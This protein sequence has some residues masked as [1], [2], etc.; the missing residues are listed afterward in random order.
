MKWVKVQLLIQNGSYIYEPNVLDGIELTSE[1]KGTP[2]KLTFKCFYDKKADFQEGNPVSFKVNNKKVFFGYIFTKKRDKDKIISVTCYDQLRYFK[3]KDTYCYEGLTAAQVLQMI[4]NDFGLKTGSIEDTGYVI[5]SRIEN[6]KTLFDVCQNALDLTLTNTNKLY[7]MYDDFARITLKSI[8]SMKIPLLIDEETGQSF[9]YS[10]SI[11]DQTYNKIKLTFDNKSTG[12]RD[13]YI[14]QDSGNINNWGILQFYDT[15]QEG[16]NGDSK[17]DSLLRYYNKKTRKLSIKDAF[18]DTRV[19]AG[20][21]VVVLLKLDDIKINN[22]M[23][24]ERVT[25]KFSNNEHTMD[26]S[27]IGGEFIA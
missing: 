16:E 24:C 15:L 9:D 10:S 22:Y 23:V 20:V 18:G 17:A 6:N 14:A 11:D 4:C 25:H 3:N 21:S 7:V 27:L 5:S 2:G 12:M 1:R 26:L 8:E 13:V 19:R